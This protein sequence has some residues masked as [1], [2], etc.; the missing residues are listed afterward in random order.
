VRAVLAG[1][2][3]VRERGQEAGRAVEVG[4]LQ[5]R[6]ADAGRIVRVRAGPARQGIGRREGESPLVRYLGFG[7]GVE[8]LDDVHRAGRAQVR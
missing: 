2:P 3:G 1:Y 5:V 8:D 6:R 4:H 7:L